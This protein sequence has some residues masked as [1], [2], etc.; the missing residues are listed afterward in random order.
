MIS[1]GKLIDNVA[2]L[3]TQYKLIDQLLCLIL[4]AFANNCRAETRWQIATPPQ[5]AKRLDEDV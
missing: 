3:I 4:G 5:N 1:S 2:K